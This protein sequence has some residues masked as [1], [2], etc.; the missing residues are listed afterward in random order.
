M[1]KLTVLSLVL[2]VF[3][4]S[5]C[6]LLEGIEDIDDVNDLI[7]DIEEYVPL[8]G[9]DEALKLATG[10][11]IE[12]VFS[13]TE[14]LTYYFYL[15]QAIEVVLNVEADFDS[16]VEIRDYDSKDVV[17]ETDETDFSKDVYTLIALDEGEYEIEISGYT[18]DTEG[19]FTLSLQL[20]NQIT[21]LELGVTA[22]GDLSSVTSGFYAITIDE[23]GLYQF[24][25][26]A[27]FDVMGIFTSLNGM[28]EYDTTDELDGLE[29]AFEVGTYYLKVMPYDLE[30]VGVYELLFEAV[31]DD[32]VEPTEP[33]EDVLSIGS[34]IM[35]TVFEG[36]ENV[37]T[38][39]VTDPSVLNIYA[40]S[41]YDTDI[42]ILDELGEQVASDYDVGD[43]NISF[44][45]LNPGIY[46]IHVL[47]Y[48]NPFSEPFDLCVEVAE[49]LPYNQ[50]D[51]TLNTQVDGTLEAGMTDRYTFTIETKGV[52]TTYLQSGLDTIG[53][54]YDAAG[55][56]V[57]R[58]DGFDPITFTET[59]D[60][61][62]EN[63]VLEPGTYELHVL[64]Y[65]ASQVG[66]YV[67]TSYFRPYAGIDHEILPGQT[68]EW[69]IVED[70][71]ISYFFYL[72]EGGY[73]TLSLDSDFDSIGRLY[74]ANETFIYSDD[75]LIAVNDDPVMGVGYDYVIE[76]VYL[77]PGFYR[78]STEGAMP[79]QYGDFA[80]T[81][82]VVY[83][84][85]DTA[86][87]IYKESQTEG[88]LTQGVN[89]WYEVELF[90]TG[91]L[92]AYL[93]SDF[94]SVGYLMDEYGRILYQDDESLGLDFY[95]SWYLEPG[96]Y[97]FVV[98]GFTPLE[99][100]DYQIITE[101][102]QYDE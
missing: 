36:E 67:L 49:N 100:G 47:A 35:D 73:V 77:E 81:L 4:L 55:N 102:V 59:P 62:I 31:E 71:E 16:R 94:D 61:K 96:V 32:P 7:D 86:T 22:S 83:G 12:G 28:V 27:D 43:F 69:L 76:G 63:T 19:L 95:L 93:D 51:L 53:I 8:E 18:G 17:F 84:D 29:V 39:D 2:F 54:L 9:I 82:E 11:E 74:D 1:K 85:M 52:F 33:A 75:E 3:L 46:E 89:D 48:T 68:V 90:N 5:G 38:L 66:E 50:E 21:P 10:G 42:Y 25:V 40:Y 13:S 58:D 72:I 34:C 14:P 30:T 92:S 15:P 64:G 56:I 65:D 37:Y 23:A 24:T 80:L 6:E 20:E 97:Y 44:L 87:H 57:S 101:F 60:F 26:D 79:G 41:T 88:S 91:T 99:H 45:E 78:I 70:G 98:T